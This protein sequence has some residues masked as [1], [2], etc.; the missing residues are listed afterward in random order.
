VIYI[1][2][3]NVSTLL[4]FRHTRKGHQIP[5]KMVVSHHVLLGIEI[6]TFGRAVSALTCLAISPVHEI[7]FNSKNRS[8]EHCKV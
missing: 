3:Y 6:K 8:G 5:L 7:I 2:I 4:P 1:Y